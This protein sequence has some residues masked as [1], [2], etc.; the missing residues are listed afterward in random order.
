MS[1]FTAVALL[2]GMGIAIPAGRR[3][4]AMVIAGATILLGPAVAAVS[5]V[6]WL[7]TRLAR[8]QA[9]RREARRRADREVVDLARVLL[10]GLSAGWSLERSLREAS[11]RLGPGLATE[12]EQVL[13]GARVDGIARALVA[14]GGDGKRL[15]R[16]LA[17]SRLG[18]TS[19]ERSL[20]AF[21]RDEVD[22]RRGE[23]IERARRLPVRMVVPLTLLMLPGFVLLVAGPTVLITGRRLLEPFIA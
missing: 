21:V 6:L 12:V 5:A 3:W 19:V 20:A 11:T 13:R 1:A 14:A 15:F 22:R 7:A 4:S 9:R 10:V 18:G 8:E 23:S 2:A 17:R 16:L